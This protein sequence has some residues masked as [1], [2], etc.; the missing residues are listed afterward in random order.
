[1]SVHDVERIL[2]TMECV[3]PVTPLCAMHYW[4]FQKQLLKAKA[5]VRRPHQLI[6]LSSKTISSLSWWISPAGF[7]AHA[8]APIREL[9]PCVKIWTDASLSRGCHSSRGEFVQRAWDP[10]DLADEP[11]INLLETRAARESVLALAQPGD[12]VRL[13]IDNRT[14]ATYILC[15][16]GTKSNILLQEALRLW[17]QAVSRDITILTPHWIPTEE[18]LAADFLSRHDMDHWEFMLDRETFTAILEHFSLYP[19]LDVFASR[20]TAQL[21]RYMSWERDPQAIGQDALIHSWDPVSYLFPPVPLLPK[22]VRLIKDQRIRAVLVCPQW[23]SA[24]WWGLMAEMMVEPPMELPYYKNILRTLDGSPV[25]PYL[26]PL[27]ALHIL[28]KNTS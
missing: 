17:E 13:H 11:S 2:G 27:V 4:S 9:A 28:G 14:A 22:V 18:N 15:Q 25:R 1:M 26:D 6:H 8:T 10:K 3:R 12:R 16:G 24:L 20:S 19:T 21:P 7:A 5:Y 23:P